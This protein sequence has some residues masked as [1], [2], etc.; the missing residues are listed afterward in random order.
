MAER[1]QDILGRQKA[2]AIEAGNWKA[3]KGFTALQRR[4][5]R[6]VA[7]GWFTQDAAIPVETP[8]NQRKLSPEQLQG[9]KSIGFTFVRDVQA[10]SLDQLSRDSSVKHLFGYVTDIAELRNIVP[11]ARQVAV[12]PKQVYVEGS[13]N[14]GYDDQLEVRDRVVR[15]LLKTPLKRGTLE[16]VDFAPDKASVL[17]QLDFAYQ[18]AFNGQKLFPNYFVRSQ[19]EYDHPGFGPDVAGVGRGV[20]GGRLGVSGWYRR[21]RCPSLGLSL[22][23]TPAGIR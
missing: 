3:A 12:N 18:V 10:L 5:A 17:V 8:D 7:R 15:K 14:L 20:R 11:V 13:E 19:D 21:G 4:I 6:G 16:G 9:L 2:A 22:V 1:I 23:A